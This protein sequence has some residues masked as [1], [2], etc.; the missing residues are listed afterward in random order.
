MNRKTSASRSEDQF[1]SSLRLVQSMSPS[2]RQELAGFLVHA[3]EWPDEWTLQAWNLLEKL[4]QEPNFAADAAFWRPL[5]DAIEP[6]FSGARRLEWIQ[7]KDSDRSL[8]ELYRNASSSRFRG[9][10]A[11]FCAT[12]G[13]IDALE[14]F[15]EAMIHD[16]PSDAND[17]AIA[18]V[19]LFQISRTQA[20]L[21]F[22]A[23][24]TGLAN[25]TV[26][27]CSLDLANFLYQHGMVQAHPCWSMRSELGA[28]LEKI[29]QR[30]QG[31]VETGGV[32]ESGAAPRDLM[33]ESG[34]LVVSL[35]HTLAR[36]GDKELIHRLRTTAELPHRQMQCEASFAL[37]SLGDEQGVKNLVRLAGDI[38]ARTR[39]LAYLTEL[40]RLD[41]APE[42]DRS[43]DAIAIGAL[44][45][46]L[47]EP[48]R[49][50]LPP[51]RIH[52][53]EV[54]S[55][56]WPGEQVAAPCRL[57]EFEYRFANGHVVGQALASPAFDFVTLARGTL[58]HDEL[59]ALLAG[60]SI[61]HPEIGSELLGQSTSAGISP[62][63]DQQCYELAKSHRMQ[64]IQ[65]HRV[66]NIFSDR[67]WIAAAER[68]GLP[69]WA[70]VIDQQ[71][72][73]YPRGLGPVDRSPNSLSS[74]DV[75]ALIVGRSV[76]R[77]FNRTNEGDPG[78]S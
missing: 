3:P 29:A 34:P 48:S 63:W 43:E 57:A 74:E 11:K 70:A 75:A 17:V 1:L 67:F 8:R 53:L 68:E 12:W 50:G 4:L 31:L 60:R 77:T 23:L 61:D 69:V 76:L 2:Q 52:L 9:R 20:H 54:K 22:P 32:V 19:P 33:R 62:Q 16:P 38:G 64:R 5:L 21:V 36:L 49:F 73:E 35:C 26:A 44:A 10:I 25:P 51:N 71:F 27:A 47:A 28:L 14:Q 7:R 15:V 45:D 41:A 46:W 55:L 66:G 30:L 39:A 72:F 6:S 78:K 59:F 24:L 18:F 13:S 42:E 37:A 56:H 40:K 58:S 65:P